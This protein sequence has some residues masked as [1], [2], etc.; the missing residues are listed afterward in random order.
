MR[1]RPRAQFR[2]EYSN[3]GDIIYSILNP[4]SAISKLEVIF[5]A[6]QAE[7]IFVNA[8]IQFI[9]ARDNIAKQERRV[10]KYFPENVLT[11]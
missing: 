10:H 1:I 2:V 9:W 7:N 3:S 5:C 11:H 8:L 4:R 6:F